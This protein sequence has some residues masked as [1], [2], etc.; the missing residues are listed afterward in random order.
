M[1]SIVI[2]ITHGGNMM[3]EKG[4]MEPPDEWAVLQFKK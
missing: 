4:D 2:I 3:N 1:P